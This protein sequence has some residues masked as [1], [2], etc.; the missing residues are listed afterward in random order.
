MAIPFTRG[1]LEV[2]L[3]ALHAFEK[4]LLRPI[5]RNDTDPYGMLP[6]A[7]LV[8]GELCEADPAAPLWRFSATQ[9]PPR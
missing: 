6:Y 7:G 1:E 9:T 8:A 4:R 5:R 3:G 2:L